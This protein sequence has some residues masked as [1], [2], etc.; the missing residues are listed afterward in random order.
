MTLLL[1]V[2]NF[3]GSLVEKRRLGKVHTRGLSIKVEE[4]D[5]DEYAYVIG[6]KRIYSGGSYLYSF[7]L[8]A[9]K[10]AEKIWVSEWKKTGKYEYG[11]DLAIYGDRIYVV[12]ERYYPS[13]H[14]RKAVLACLRK[15]DGELL[16]EKEWTKDNGVYFWNAKIIIYD[17]TIHLIGGLYKPSG[18][19]I[20]V[21]K[22][23]LDGTLLSSYEYSAGNYIDV[24]VSG[25][26]IQG[27]YIY[28]AGER[29]G[30]KTGISHAILYCFEMGSSLNKIWEETYGED[31]YKAYNWF[32]D[33]K[34]Y[35]DHIYVVGSIFK[36]FEDVKGIIAK[37]D[38]DG[39]R[40]WLGTYY[41]SIIFLTGL[42][43]YNDKMYI[44]GVKGTSYLSG[45]DAMLMQVTEYFNLKIT[46]PG[47]EYWVNVEGDKKSGP[48]AEYVLPMGIHEVQVEDVV[49]DNGVRHYFKQWSDGVTDNPRTV[50]L[51]EDTELEAQYGIQYYVTVDTVYSTASGEGWYDEGET[52][53]ISVAETQIDQGN[54]TRR[55]FEG[56]NLGGTVVSTD[57]SYS[58]AVNEPQA[59]TA[60][61]KTQYYVRVYTD[62]S[63]ASGEG[64]YD[65]G[66][67]ATVSVAETLIQGIPFNK[68]FKGWRD[69][70]GAIV[71]SQQTYSFTV[72]TAKTLTAVWE[73]ELNLI[74][75]A[76][77]GAAV[78][79]VA[80]AILLMRR[81]KPAAPAYPPPPPP[82]P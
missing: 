35:R 24:Y 38:L 71:A 67:V 81:K 28:I 78:A 57:Q 65:E 66:G 46:T 31:V 60:E 5:G 82:P 43:I 45:Y 47:A 7:L 51:Y 25:A 17:D 61:W 74:A 12:G 32:T 3:D 62:Y 16:W 41:A 48:S 42:E 11:V 58:F 69:Q 49:E 27:S 26:V 20:V 15:S 23:S 40:K 52:A 44:C 79:V 6:Y 53:T 70:T 22:Y 39:N 4:V 2:T 9:F 14:Y 8:V 77:I 72:D 33:L 64:W 75:V 29:Y 76:G 63:T 59:Y 56:W 55:I 50:E 37:Y 30:Y 19:D 13:G 10:N 68:V 54:D 34:I 73:D 18:I 1:L 36:T 80:A 21:L